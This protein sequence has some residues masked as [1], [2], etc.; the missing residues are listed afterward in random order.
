MRRRHGATVTVGVHVTVHCVVHSGG[1][2]HAIHTAVM[3]MLGAAR[4]RTGDRRRALYR[5]RHTGHDMVERRVHEANAARGRP[6]RD[7]LWRRTSTRPTAPSAAGASCT[8]VRGRCRPPGQPA[9]CTPCGHVVD[10]GHVTG[11]WPRL[12]FVKHVL[13]VCVFTEQTLFGGLKKTAKLSMVDNF[14]AK[15]TLFPL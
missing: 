14:R 6:R 2:L 13:L 3:V 12:Y 4:T 15:T 11:T 5:R 10:T 8:I 1:D 9:G 7:G